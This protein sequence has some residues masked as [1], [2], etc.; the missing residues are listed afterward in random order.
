M[1]KKN[2]RSQIVDAFRSYMQEKGVDE[3]TLYKVMEESFRNAIAKMYGSDSNFDVIVNPDRGDLEIWRNREIVPDGEVKD[4]MTQVSISEALAGGEDDLEVGEEYTDK[5][6]FEF[7]GR[8][9]IQNLKQSMASKVRELDM[10]NLYA[11]YSKR[12]GELILADVYQVWKKELLLMDAEGNELILPK[13]NLIPRDRFK[14]GDQVVAI[15][16][17]VEYNN[18]NPKIILSR[19]SDDFMRRLFEREV[20]EIQD[21]FVTIKAV[22]RIPG[23][24]AKVAVESYDDRIDPV[25]AVVGVRGSRIQGVVNELR[26]ESIDVLQYTNNPVLFIQRALS[27]AKNVQVQ[28]NEEEKRADVY[29][30][31][32]EIKKAIGKLGY[33]IKLAMSLTAYQID[34]YRDEAQ[35]MDEGDL[36]LT[37]FNDAIEQWIIDILLG[38][39]CDTAK[40]VL[41][42]S[43]EDL[44]RATDLEEKTIHHVYQE[45]MT[46][47]SDEE[48]SSD[49][50]P[51]LPQRDPAYYDG[52]NE[53]KQV[54]KVDKEVL[55]KEDSA[56]KVEEVSS[57][58]E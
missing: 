34:I 2:E 9:A 57:E 13:A 35:D 55:E 8:R 1:A 33:N 41:K 26:N 22:A 30:P 37:E 31:R 29:L 5:V 40:S 36:F 12:T 14:K 49:L 25:G 44:V 27:P 6:E 47:F 54:A 21:G 56:E 19:T 53:K 45:L 42:R 17:H 15:I 32:E 46:E 58:E 48:L 10:D 18:N 43:P 52:E 11:A 51:H 16:D 20:P 4:S 28:I 50:F 3:A 24:R 23:E 38:V 7:F 39:G